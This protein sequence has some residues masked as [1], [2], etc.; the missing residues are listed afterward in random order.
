MLIKNLRITDHLRGVFTPE[1]TNWNL[2]PPRS[3]ELSGVIK[4]KFNAI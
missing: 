1:S 2:I 3:D 4:S